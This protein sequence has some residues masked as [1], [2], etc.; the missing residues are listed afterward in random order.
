MLTLFHPFRATATYTFH[1]HTLSLEFSF[2]V[3]ETSFQRTLL[4]TRTSQL[5]S[6]KT[7]A[8]RYVDTGVLIRD[9]TS[10]PFNSERHAKA[11]ARMNWLHSRHNISNDDMLYTLSVFVTGPDKWLGLYDWRGL[12]ELE[13]NVITRCPTLSLLLDL[14]FV[15]RVYG[16][17]CDYGGNLRVLSLLRRI[18][19]VALDCNPRH[20][21]SSNTFFASLPTFFIHL[22]TFRH[23][24][25]SGAK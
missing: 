11:L 2:L 17:L 13:V 24:G 20:V 22:L 14:L 6:V 7:G 18:S 19:L 3:I 25:S 21:H 23:G 5:L 8:R 9:F 12:T 16:F 4:T 15:G 10:F 1:S